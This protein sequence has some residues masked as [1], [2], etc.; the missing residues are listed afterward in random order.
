MSFLYYCVMK[1]VFAICGSTKTDSANHALLQTIQQLCSDTLNI[2]IYNGLD[3]LPYFDP[4]PESENNHPQVVEF[5]H[6]IQ[7][8]DGVIIC[9]PEYVFSLPGILKN[10]LEWTVSSIVFSGKPAALITASSS[11]KMAHESLLHIMN[12]LGVVT[13]PE[14]C[15]HIQ[16]IKSKMTPEGVIQDATTRTQVEQLI[17]AFKRLIG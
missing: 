2:T 5:R 11:G 9:T 1:Q 6:Q 13:T 14:T 8:A 12:T 17:M 15:L 16:S 4:T 7:H 3:Q 10:A